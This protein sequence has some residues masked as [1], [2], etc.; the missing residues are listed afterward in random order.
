MRNH[1]RT[2]AVCHRA[3]NTVSEAADLS[4]VR[5]LCRKCFNPSYY[6]KPRGAIREP[7]PIEV[8]A[9]AEAA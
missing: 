8:E 2:C 4:G 6:D 1:N 3:I 7:D 5:L 9:G